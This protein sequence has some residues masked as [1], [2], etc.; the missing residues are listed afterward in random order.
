M[1]SINLIFHVAIG[2]HDARDILELLLALI[3][4]HLRLLEVLY[5]CELVRIPCLQKRALEMIKISVLRS[6]G[7]ELTGLRLKWCDI[8]AASGTMVF[9]DDSSH[10]NSC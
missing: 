9:I 7:L 5:L 4:Q 3:R 8:C 6:S 1:Q 10:R 2:G